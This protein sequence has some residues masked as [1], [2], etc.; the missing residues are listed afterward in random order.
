MTTA[1]HQANGSCRSSS[2]SITIVIA[3][4]TD[5][6]SLSTTLASCT[7]QRDV[8][9]DVIVSL[10]DKGAPR[11]ESRTE[12]G[13]TVTTIRRDDTGIANAW[14]HAIDRVES[15]LV[16]F[17]GSGDRFVSEWSL[18]QL[19]AGSSDDGGPDL[20]LYGDQLILRPDGSLDPFPAPKKNHEHRALRGHMVIPHASSLWPTVV[21]KRLRFDETFRIAID[22]EFALRARDAV[23]YRHVPVAVAVITTGGL[24]NRPGM[25]LKVV[26]EDARAKLK[27]GLTPASAFNVNAKRILRWM[28][29]SLR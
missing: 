20:V 22:Y 10:K 21:V 3:A 26:A 14:N 17:V 23:R 16:G 24:S 18:S 13:C 27:N 19:V 9:L 8:Q 4:L 28:M 6:D 15:D 7:S 12:A 2:P 11:I 25:L 29:S 1:S 5:D